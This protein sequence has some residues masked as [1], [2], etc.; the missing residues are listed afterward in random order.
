MGR[1]AVHRWT[2]VHL[3]ICVGGGSWLRAAGLKD[4]SAARLMALG[5]TEPDYGVSNSANAMRSPG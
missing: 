5:G 2:Y 1:R 4:A 3:D